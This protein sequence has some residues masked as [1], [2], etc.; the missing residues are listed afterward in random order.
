MLAYELTEAA[1]ADLQEIARYTVTT[2][3][4]E[5]ARR[6]EMLLKNHFEAIGQQ[7]ANA[8]AFLDRRPELLVSRVEH[9]FVF[10]LNRENECPLILAVFHEKMDLMNRLRKR[11]GV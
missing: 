1:D 4:M 5:Q 2:W 9:H 6:Y 8:R 11:L 7:T 3:G 10:H